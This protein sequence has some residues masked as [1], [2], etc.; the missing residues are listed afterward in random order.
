MVK[1]KLLDCEEKHEQC[2][3]GLWGKYDSSLFS[4]FYRPK[5]LDE[6]LVIHKEND[7][8][9]AALHQIECLSLM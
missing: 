4:D 7:A 1:K 5:Q 9:G 6:K 3:L 2:D 8:L